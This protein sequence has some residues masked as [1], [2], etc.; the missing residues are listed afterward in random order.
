MGGRIEAL[1]ASLEEDLGGQKVVTPVVQERRCRVSA[2]G[3][4]A[5]RAPLGHRSHV[6]LTTLPF[7]GRQTREPEGRPSCRSDCNGRLAGV[8]P[9]SA[10][11]EQNHT[12]QCLPTRNPTNF[13]NECM[14]NWS[15][16]L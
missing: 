7:S 16:G 12:Y 4:V 6:R 5:L 1:I 13:L 14:N 2:A 9:R 10:W 15:N 3:G 8:V 11:R